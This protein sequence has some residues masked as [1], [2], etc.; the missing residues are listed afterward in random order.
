MSK[1]LNSLNP[2]FVRRN[3]SGITQPIGFGAADVIPEGW[4]GV[5][6]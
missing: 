2:T 5:E 4:H 3:E 6:A 1:S